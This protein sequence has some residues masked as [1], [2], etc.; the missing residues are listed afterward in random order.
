LLG[1]DVAPGADFVLDHELLTEPP[2]QL[3]RSDAREQVGNP[4]RRERDD[5][6]HRSGRISLC[7]GGTGD[8]HR[9]EYGYE[10][11]EC[12]SNGFHLS[13]PPQVRGG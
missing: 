11:R 13:S 2:G 9:C 10:Y 7:G 1:A 5:H 6:A 3:L 4:A 12:V 8:E